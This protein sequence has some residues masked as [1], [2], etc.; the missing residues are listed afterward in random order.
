MYL[1]AFLAQGVFIATFTGDSFLNFKLNSW[2]VTLGRFYLTNCSGF[3]EFLQLLA[4][5][6]LLFRSST[7][8]GVVDSGVLEKCSKNEDEAHDQVNVDGLHIRN[9]R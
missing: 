7:P 4:L 5:F 9:S 1:I 6:T 8:I 3:S 2:H